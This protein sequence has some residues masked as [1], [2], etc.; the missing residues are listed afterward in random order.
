MKKIITVAVLFSAFL[1]VT[2]SAQNKSGYHVLKTFHIK[3]GGGYDYTTV[4]S[5][6]NRLYVSHGTQVNVLDKTTGDSIG[7]I[8][9]DKDVH[10]IAL[11]HELGKGY[12]TNGSANSVVVFDLKTFKILAHVPAGTFA[13]GIM[14]DD[15]SKKVISCNGR[16]KN[17]TVIDPATDQ[18]I[19]TIQ[20]S[21]WPETATSDGK[22]KIYVNNAEKSE[23]DVID[24]NTF[25]VVNTWPI[26]PGVRASGLSMD[27]NTMRLFAGCDNKVLIVMDATNGKVVT[28]IPIGD[29]CDAVGFDKKL[30][31]VYSSNGDGTL[32]I[33]KEW[34]ADKFTVVENLQTKKG[35]RTNAVDQI[36][37]LV[38]L[39][40][41]DFAPKKAGAF[42]PSIIPGTFQVLVVGK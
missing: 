23:I 24:A 40:T 11:V 20:L 21:G 22:G 35:A 41:G 42:R 25:K 3:S 13:D 36:T 10:G 30:K 17:M 14:Y 38:Y 26:A 29:E 8:A 34:S 5:A 28:S 4:D 16:S 37:H 6:S 12:I 18:A 2:A 32:T 19:A 1:A 27:R 31:T 7:V 33:I 39:P 15:Y 9:T